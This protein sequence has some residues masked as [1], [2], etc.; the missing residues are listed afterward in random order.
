MSQGWKRICSSFARESEDLCDS[1]ACPARKICSCYVDPSSI[2]ALMACRLIAL[3]KNPGIRPIGI[4]KVCHRL[5]GKSVLS[6]IKPDIL[7][8]KGCQQLCAGQKSSCEAIV[9]CVRELYDS[10]EVEGVLC[11]D[12]T[13]AYNSLNR[14]LALCNILHLCPS[15]GR[16]M[17]NTYRFDC[18]LFIDGDCIFSCEGTTQGD[19]LAMS[20]FAV[21]TVSLIQQLDEV[22]HTTQLWYADDATGL[23]NLQELRLWWDGIRLL[24]PLYGYYANDKKTVLLVKEE[25]FERAKI[26]FQGTDV[27][28]R[29][30]G[31]I[32]LGSPIGINSFVEK[33]IKRKVDNWVKDLTLLSNMAD[34]QPQAAFSAFGH[35]LF[36]RWMYFFRTCSIPPDLL[37]QLENCFRIVFIPS[38]SGRS[39]VSDVER[40]WLALNY[41]C[42]GP[43]MIYPYLLSVQQYQASRVITQPLVRCLRS[44]CK[45]LPFEVLE[46]QE[47]IISKFSKLRAQEMTT[48]TQHV[49]ESLHSDCQRLMDVA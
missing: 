5:I 40:E 46:E 43:G 26:C 11:V 28:I 25:H 22:S 6:V 16:L 45:E 8:V 17:T 21:A 18:S 35:G 14:E 20:M 48:T 31:I 4:G 38:L 10:E 42:G 32:L 7:D 37:S 44:R 30:D 15:F 39:S 13:N 19:P 34:V 12:A 1:L 47:K 49:R 9:H 41:H 36:S 29:T 27:N 33:Q 23:G 3:N 24:G 2:E